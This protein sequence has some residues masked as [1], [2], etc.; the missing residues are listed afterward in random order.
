MR[1]MPVL[2]AALVA[3]AA[4]SSS[5]PPQA[6]KPSGKAR[7]KTPCNPCVVQV[8]L[9]DVRGKCTATAPAPDSW[10]GHVAP[11]NVVQW[12]VQNDCAK[13]MSVGV[14]CFTPKY[15]GMDKPNEIDL[16]PLDAQ[17]AT[18]YKMVPAKSKDTLE[19]RVRQAAFHPR[20][21]VYSIVSPEGVLVDPEM[22]IAP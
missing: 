4:N 11:G 7:A 16:N 22:E 6:N 15:K 3:V 8:V 2:A 14:N 18:S 9:T 21:Y 10:V 1:I 17:C 19:C 20:T 5:A 12:I 13:P